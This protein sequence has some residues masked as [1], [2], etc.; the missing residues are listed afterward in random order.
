MVGVANS[1]VLRPLSWRL[2]GVSSGGG[3]DIS[4]PFYLSK[5]TEHGYWHGFGPDSDQSRGAHHLLPEESLARIGGGED[6]H[7]EAYSQG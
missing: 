3:A 2:S 6:G 5:E 1:L 4:P 7:H